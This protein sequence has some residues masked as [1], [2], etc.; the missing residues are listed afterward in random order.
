M[1]I[2][3]HHRR[4]IVRFD[5][6]LHPTAGWLSRQVTEA[7]PW[8]PAPRFLLRARDSSYG[9]AFSK[10]V[11]AMDITE[12]LTAPRSPWRNPTSSEPLAR[13][14]ASVWTTSLSSTSAIC[15]APSRLTR[16]ITEPE[17]ICSWGKTVPILAL[18]IPPA[19]GNVIA[20]AQ[21][22]GL[23]HRHERLAA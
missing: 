6:T 9:P 8:H 14:G 23:H 15:V 11:D 20:I 12:V 16:T 1:L 10:R 18:C 2:L 19:R 22:G 21:V 17:R 13:S 4:K 5:V 3:A 7:F